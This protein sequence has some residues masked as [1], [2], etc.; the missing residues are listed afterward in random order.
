MQVLYPR[1][2][3]LDVHKDTV[4]ACVRCVSEPLH[5]ETRSFAT[6]TSGLLVLGEWLAEHACT[7]VALEAT[8][9]YWRPLWHVLEGPVVPVLASAQPHKNVPGPRT[10]L[11]RSRGTAALLARTSC[12]P[13]TL[14]G[15]SDHPA[16]LLHDR[17]AVGEAETGAFAGRLRGAKRF[18]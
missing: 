7:H 10:A 11:K 12:P 17:V 2:A 13:P 9:I 1:C 18:E 15:E 8:D 4:V 5:H 6:T 14:S 3:G 16:A